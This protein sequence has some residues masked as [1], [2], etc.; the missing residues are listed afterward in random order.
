MKFSQKILAGLSALLLP[1]P[2]VLSQPALSIRQAEGNVIVSWPASSPAMRVESKTDLGQTWTPANL[3]PM[4]QNGIYTVSYPA[5]EARRLFRVVCDQAEDCDPVLNVKG[6]LFV[7]EPPFG[8]DD[9]PGNSMQ[10]LATL[11][12][13]IE[14]A[15]KLMPVTSVYVAPGTYSLAGPLALASGVSIYGQFDGT[16]NWTRSVENTT[17]LRGP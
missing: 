11:P 7:A 3:Q 8:S 5:N 16:T 9:N 13:A 14:L 12:K 15:A 1:T 10:P 2:Y 17:V 4:A 6:P